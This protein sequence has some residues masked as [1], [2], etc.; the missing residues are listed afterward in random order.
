M[1]AGKDRG[2][3]KAEAKAATCIPMKWP[4]DGPNPR[5]VSQ[6][7]SSLTPR[8]ALPSGD[9]EAQRAHPT[10]EAGRVLQERGQPGALVH[11]ALHRQEAAAEL[12]HQARAHHIAASAK[13]GVLSARAGQ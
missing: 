12:V 4:Q 7:G 6:A 9:R 10:Q 11:R 13:K 3:R 8:D 2:R 5:G 1:G